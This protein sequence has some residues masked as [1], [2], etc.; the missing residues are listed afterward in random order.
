MKYIVPADVSVCIF[1]HYTKSTSDLLFLLLGKIINRY[2][3]LE[4]Y[5]KKEIFS[6]TITIY[7][8]V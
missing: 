3:N 5:K 4:N 8:I 7:L 2:Q 6:N 1:T